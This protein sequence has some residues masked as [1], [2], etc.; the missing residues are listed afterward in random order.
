M[1]RKYDELMTYVEKMQALGM[2]QG[3]FGWDLETEPFCSFRD[4]MDCKCF[5]IS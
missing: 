3:L 1:D 2:A 4:A 5:L